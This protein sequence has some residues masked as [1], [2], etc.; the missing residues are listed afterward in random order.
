MHWLWR[1]F[2][3]SVFLVLIR[4]LFVPQPKVFISLPEEQNWGQIIQGEMR[5]WQ[6]LSQDL[7][8]SIE[9]EVRRLWKDFKPNGQGKEV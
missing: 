7:P 4:M 9:V 5:Q 8:A 1:L 2:I 3:L 6:K